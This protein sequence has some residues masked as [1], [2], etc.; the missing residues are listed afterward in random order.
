MKEEDKIFQWFSHSDHFKEYRLYNGPYFTSQRDLIGCKNLHSF[1]D[2][3]KLYDANDLS[4]TIFNKIETAK[5]GTIIKLHKTGL[6]SSIQ[7][8]RLS[9][10]Q[11]DL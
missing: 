4:K 2:F 6:T 9:Q 7:I 1:N 10:E 5:V 11:L 8:K 3:K